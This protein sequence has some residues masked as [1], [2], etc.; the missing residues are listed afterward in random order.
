MSVVAVQTIESFS[1][2]SL[3]LAS[4]RTH[5][6]AQPDRVRVM[7][8]SSS[9]TTKSGPSPA[10][11][12][13]VA[14]PQAVH[15]LRRES[16][17]RTRSA[18]VSPAP[19]LSQTQTGRHRTSSTTSR[20][21]SPTNHTRERVYSFSSLGA[22]SIPKADAVKPVTVGSEETIGSF[23]PTSCP[24]QHLQSVLG[25][26]FRT[27]QLKN[28][29][30][31]LKLSTHSLPPYKSSR[32]PDDVC[33]VF[34]S[35]PDS[36]LPSI[37]RTPSS[38]TDSEYFPTAPSSAGPLTPVHSTTTSPTLRKRSLQPSEILE[39][40]EAQSK[41]RVRT[42]CAACHRPGSNF[43]CC[44]RC[45]EMWCSRECRLKSGNGRRHICSNISN[46]Q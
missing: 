4:S 23:T 10:P 9:R 27:G 11:A 12:S 33:T 25:T 42:S 34:P 18:T 6:S 21:M 20:A 16:H 17:T 40:L 3:T 44:P 37:C 5:R 39:V 30:R 8:S 26:S 24:R 38:E 46:G 29:A 13:H 43:P 36:P 1:P 35:P 15:N 45:G 22:G 28:I 31:R 41:F 7:S 2:G 19:Q 14:F 32:G